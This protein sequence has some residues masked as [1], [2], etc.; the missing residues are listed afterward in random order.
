[1][2]ATKFLILAATV[3]EWNSRAVHDYINATM[4]GAQTEP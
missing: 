4:K 1:M 3:A 2:E